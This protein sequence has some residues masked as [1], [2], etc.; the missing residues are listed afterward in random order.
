MVERQHELNMILEVSKELNL[1]PQIGFR[2]KLKTEAGGLW[3]ESSGAG[4]KFGL[5][6]MQLIEAVELLSQWN[7]L[8]CVQ[9]IHFHIGS[10]IP[11]I[12]PIKSAIKETSRFLSELYQLGCPIKYVDVGGGL[13]V[14][15]D[16]SGNPRN[17]TNYDVQEYA[18]DIVFNLQS[19]CDESNIPHPDIISESGRFIVAQSSL[20]VMDVVDHNAIIQEKD[21]QL[22]QVDSSFL[23]DMYDIYK[24]VSLKSLRESFNDL[25]EKQKEMHEL[26]IYGVLSLKDMA[27]AE[28]IY[29][30]TALKIKTL[31]ENQSDYDDIFDSL[32]N[33]LRDT[34]FCNFSIFQSLPDSWA[35]SYRFP[36][37][38]LHRLKEKPN[39]QACLVDLT[40]D[41]DGKL[42]KF[43]DYQTWAMESYL[44]VHEVKK[45][46]SYLMGI[47]LTGAYQEILGDLHNLFGDTDAVHITLTGK[48][49][50]S[51]DHRLEG[52]S[53][54]EVLN[55]V[56]FQR[57]ELLHKIHETTEGSVNKGK[58]SRQEA[59]VLLKKFEET[60]SHSTYLK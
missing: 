1:K 12:Q 49:R 10:Q 11:S 50:Y 46:E 38:P 36:V 31:S 51:I 7:L 22:K 42:D 53:I 26:F 27:L 4:S 60:L 43:L 32:K 25:I 21:I 30:N 52:D 23:N 18:N 3:S 56:E 58:L 48:E 13:G 20:L 33:Q 16:G 9:L 45:N 55:Y 34:Y 41:S 37:V 44:P 5:S 2:L 35:L 29:W 59:G 47:F 39:K 28:K 8:D 14:D 17:S 54:L 24:N 57:R 40:C 15:Y 6:S 19:I